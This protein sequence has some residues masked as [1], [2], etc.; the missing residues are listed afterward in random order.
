MLNYI[1]AEEFVSRDP[2]TAEKER[3]RGEAEAPGL[4]RIVWRGEEEG[5]PKHRTAEILVSEDLSDKPTK[6]LYHA[7]FADRPFVFRVTPL[8]VESLKRVPVKKE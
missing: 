7:R 4:I 6:P 2:Q 8:L 5:K 1:K 3:L